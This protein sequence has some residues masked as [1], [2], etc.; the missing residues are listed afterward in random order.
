M[1]IGSQPPVTDLTP[2][3]C[4]PV[5]YP[6]INPM[7]LSRLHDAAISLNECLTVAGIKYGFFADYAMAA[8][9][10]R[11]RPVNHFACLASASATQV[12]KAL[13]QHKAFMELNQQSKTLLADCT[14][15]CWLSHA[16]DSEAAVTI[17]IYY[18]TFLGML[19]HTATPL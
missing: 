3:P 11:S 16:G 4:E 9:L 5:G 13:A 10:D 2:A 17:T 15:F 1:N 19:Q 6:K 7:R 18:D 8:S 12:H 14:H